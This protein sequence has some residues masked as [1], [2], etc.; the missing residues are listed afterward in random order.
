MKGPKMHYSFCR[1]E[2]KDEPSEEFTRIIASEDT[3]GAPEDELV[4]FS[5]YTS[6]EL[7]EEANCLID[8]KEDWRCLEVCSIVK[9][10]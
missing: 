5:G 7:Q 9:Q 8:L 2:W 3:E 4:F 6:R 10:L 1:L